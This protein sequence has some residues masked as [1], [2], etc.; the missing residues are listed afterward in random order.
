MIHTELKQHFA[1]VSTNSG[2][3]MNLPKL[4]VKAKART[5]NKVLAA[6]LNCVYMCVC[7]AVVTDAVVD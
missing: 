6:V 5:L 4:E 3:W 7:V 1:N 2:T